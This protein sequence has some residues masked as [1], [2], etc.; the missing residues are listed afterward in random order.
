MKKNCSKHGF[1]EYVANGNNQFR[2]RKCKAEAIVRWRQRTK[3][4]AIAYLGGKCNI[5][6]YNKCVYA[7]EFHHR[8]PKQK[9]FGISSS[10]STRAWARVKKEL[11]K[12]V[13]LC[14]NCHREVEAGV[15]KIQ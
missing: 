13:L 10:G 2:C 9:S 5:C 6:D 3:Q 1:T 12:C 15:A 4:R 14:A 11:D 8:D 7:L